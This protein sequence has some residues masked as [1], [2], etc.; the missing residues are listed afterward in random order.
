MTTKKKTNLQFIGLFLT[1]VFLAAVLSGCGNKNEEGLEELFPELDTGDIEEGAI[2]EFEDGEITSEEFIN[3]LRVQTFLYPDSYINDREFRSKIIK[4]TIMRKVL[5][6]EADEDAKERAR[7][8][9]NDL[10]EDIKN[11]YSEEEIEYAYEK[12]DINEKDIEDTLISIFTTEAYFRSQITNEDKLDFY[13]E[14]SAE[15]TT[16]N[17]THI[18]VMTQEIKP[19]GEVNKIRTEEKALEKANVLYKKL[20]EGSDINELATEYSD[21]KGSVNNGGRYENSNISNL[22]PEFRD[23]VLEQKI[24]EVGEPVKTDYGYHLIKVEELEVM[25]FEEIEERI[26]DQLSYEKYLEYLSET[27]PELIIDI[28][29]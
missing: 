6:E 8:Q 10:L 28:K 14:I 11:H 19:G 1:L 26:E 3:L 5:S 27:I 17:F 13:D 18:L 7:K 25:H 22:V 20:K 21:D 15:L 12:L 23:A 2:A 16:A 24:G 4:E 9:A 29:L